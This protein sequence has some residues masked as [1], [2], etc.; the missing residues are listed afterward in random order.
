MET[1]IDSDYKRAFNL[2]YE[3]AKELDLKKPMFKGK[4]SLQSSTN[5]MQAGML[6]HIKEVTLLRNRN[7]EKHVPKTIK[8]KVEKKRRN[9]NRGKGFSL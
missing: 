4:D 7:I 1:K 5:A 3:I 6:Q 2:G 8:S 9:K